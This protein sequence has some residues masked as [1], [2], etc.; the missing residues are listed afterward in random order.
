MKPI[1]L[2]LLLFVF[3][4]LSVLAAPTLEGTHK[5]WKVYRIREGGKALC[6]IAS[7]PVKES[8]SFSKRGKPYAI[9]TRRSSSQS[10][11]N[12]SSGYEY[13][14]HREVRLTV[15]GKSW[16]LFTQGE[17]AWAK[18]EQED[19]AIIA[20]MKRENRM[21]VKGTSAKNTSSQDI[22]SLAGFSAAFGQMQ[23]CKP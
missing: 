14:P 3:S 13:K 22:Y 15:G 5:N 16:S 21:I 19:T 18:T 20:A 1:A 12:V 10:E 2:A 9:V 8:G 6:Y 23:D 11:V 7:E 4:G 17:Q